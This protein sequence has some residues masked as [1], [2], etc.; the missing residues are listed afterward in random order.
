[1]GANAVRKAYYAIDYIKVGRTP[2]DGVIHAYVW[3]VWW[4][5]EPTGKPWRTPDAVGAVKQT[6]DADSALRGS[7]DHAEIAADQACRAA[8]GPTVE[9]HMID[10]SF[11]RAAYREASGNP[12]RYVAPRP[13]AAARRKQARPPASEAGAWWKTRHAQIDEH[14]RWVQDVCGRQAWSE[15][16]AGPGAAKATALSELG[17]PATATEADVKRAFKQRCL[18]EHPDHGGTD[19]RFDALVNVRDR[20]LAAVR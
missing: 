5:G 16:L 19:A 1:V 3:A 15:L 8:C 7:A 12:P 9:T 11:A 20:A 2:T 13:R 17:L 18:T 14:F 10:E 4:T 6:W